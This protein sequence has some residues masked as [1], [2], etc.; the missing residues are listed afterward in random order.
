MLDVRIKMHNMFI[1]QD[2]VLLVDFYAF[3]QSMMGNLRLKHN[4]SAN[5]AVGNKDENS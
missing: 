5:W 1:G 4:A 3:K 2:H